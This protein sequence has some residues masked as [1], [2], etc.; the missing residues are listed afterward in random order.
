MAWSAPMT[1]VA[2][3][4]FTAAQFNT[5]VRDNLNETMPAKATLDGQYAVAT[6]SNAIAMRRADLSSN[7]AQGSTTSTTYTGTIGAGGS[8]PS[9]T[10]TT[11]TRAAVFLLSEISNNTASQASWMSFAVTGASSIASSDSRA[12]RSGGTTTLYKGGGWV[13]LL[14]S[15]TAGSNTFTAEY[16]V[17]GGTGFWD[18][19][20]IGVIPF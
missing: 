2:G 20:K 16:K 1:A 11:G 8:G 9:V 15:L 3:T 18:D 7:A 4:Q 5:N 12:I 19:R 13:A 6:G 17:S 10:V 14:T